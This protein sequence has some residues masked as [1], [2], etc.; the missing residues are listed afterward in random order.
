MKS[1]AFS[2][3]YSLYWDLKYVY[4]WS[5]IELKIEMRRLPNV[6]EVLNLVPNHE[7]SRGIMFI[8]SV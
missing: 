2:N 4:L 7:S 3:L 8:F 1:D 5:S 6:I